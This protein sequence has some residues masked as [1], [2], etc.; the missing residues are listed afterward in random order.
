MHQQETLARFRLTPIAAAFMVA[1]VTAC[2]GGSGG[3]GSSDDDDSAENGDLSEGQSQA[4]ATTTATQVSNAA[5][6]ARAGSEAAEDFD[7]D[8]LTGA[9]TAFTQN[10]QERA[11]TL[12]DSGALAQGA[13]EDGCDSGSITVNENYTDGNLQ[14]TEFVANECKIAADE[15]EVDLEFTINGT[16]RVLSDP[17]TRDV[18][19]DSDNFTA[20][21]EFSMDEIVDENGNTVFPAIGPI[22][23]DFESDGG[24]EATFSSGGDQFDMNMDWML[25]FG[26]SCSGQGF[27]FAMESSDL[28]VTSADQG[29]GRWDTTVNGTVAWEMSAD[30][31]D[32]SIDEE[33][34]YET[35]Q[36]LS[37]VTGGEPD[38]GELNV[39][40]GGQTVNIVYVQGGVEVD[41]EFYTQEDLAAKHEEELGADLETELLGNCIDG[42]FQM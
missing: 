35:V 30:V 33:V 26:M 28:E 31:W 10:L 27:N 8:A 22:T 24:Y 17:A 5:S 40:V 11:Q 9:Q 15:E 36:P 1:F 42:D 21:L 25:A 12:M 23:G 20:S 19:V 4:V 34:T 32:T 37:A 39:E 41:G 14:G 2:G 7:E 3:G 38:S 29:S 16:Q 13:G 18:K 6:G